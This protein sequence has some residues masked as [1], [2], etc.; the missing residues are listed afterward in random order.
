MLL[1]S[2][3][4]TTA[5]DSCGDGN[6]AAI[7]TSAAKTMKNFMVMM[8]PRDTRLKTAKGKLIANYL[9]AT[10][11]IVRKVQRGEMVMLTFCCVTFFITTLNLTKSEI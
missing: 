1:F 3:A 9:P 11:F 2:L 10:Y 7:A 5:A 4:K 6:A 8:G